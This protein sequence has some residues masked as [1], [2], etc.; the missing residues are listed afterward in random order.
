MR[1]CYTGPP[2][3]ENVGKCKAGVQLC[4]S[5][6]WGTCLGEVV[7]QPELG[8]NDIDEDCDG[9]KPGN[10]LWSVRHGDGK[11]QFARRIAVDAAGNA[12]VSGYHLGQLSIGGLSDAGTG[13]VGF[14]AK[15]NG[16][17]GKGAWIRSITLG[18]NARA[19]GVAVDGTQVFVGGDYDQG[20]RG[21][22]QSY[23]LDGIQGWLTQIEGAMI[24]SVARVE[25]VAADGKGTVYAVG[26]FTGTINVG[27]YL[28]T[29][30]G[31][32]DVFVAR[33]NDQSG[34]VIGATSFGGAADDTVADAATCADGVLIAGTYSGEPAIQLP[35]AT[36]SYGTFVAKYNANGS[37]VWMRGFVSNAPQ[38]SR[39][40]AIAADASCNAFV[41]G[42]LYGTVNFDANPITAGVNQAG[43]VAKLDGN[44]NGA[45]KW[46]KAFPSAGPV[47]VTG[48]AVDTAGALAVAGK[49]EN[50][51]IVDPQGAAATLPAVDERDLFL[52][53]LD[54]DGSYQWAASFATDDGIMK[55]LDGT[56][57]TAFGAGGDV[58][59]AGDWNEALV[60][61]AAGG[62]VDTFVAKFG[63]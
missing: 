46:A 47:E 27:P 31:G 61:G 29:N 49:F 42:A 45:V 1:P 60:F 25:A 32:V 40:L 18:T 24:G 9:A 44:A 55:P 33:L 21:F 5:D 52:A 50:S 35:D 59:I 4:E 26:T 43:F 6:V 19:L 14:L 28:L 30:Q 53:K 48:I 20:T 37:N 8:N 16:A 34:G 58:L 36:N 39:G 23:G 11:D 17:D 22:V 12:Y 13:Q 62:N 3:T 51:V 41:A 54:Q 2:G 57:R 7:P 56:I 63:P 38:G 10:T 15:L